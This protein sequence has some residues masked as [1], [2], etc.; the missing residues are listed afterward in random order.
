MNKRIIFPSGDGG[1]CVLIPAGK[2]GIPIEEIAR[3]DVPA[4]V[5]Y[6]II[7]AT[8]VPDDRTE[9]GLWSAD[10]TNPDGHGIGPDAWF[11]EQEAGE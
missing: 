8:D 9:R 10:F 3:K 5:P 6:R 4:G 2:S 7:E 1:V 11:A